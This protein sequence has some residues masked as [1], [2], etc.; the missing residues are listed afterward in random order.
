MSCTMTGASPSEGSSSNNSL[1]RDIK[2]RP[3]ASICCSPPLM[4]LAIWSLRSR[5]RGNR[6]KIDS[7][8]FSISALSLRTKAPRRRFSVTV[9]SLKTRLPSGTWAMPSFRILSA[10]I[11]SMFL[12]SN[13]ISPRDGWS[14]P[15]I[16]RRVVLLPAPFEPIKVTK[17]ESPT[18]SEMPFS[19]AT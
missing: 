16:A 18:S 12:P 4:V 11:F 13:R 3:I 9:K 1:G 19:A 8:S 14:S 5:N 17:S 15:E 10:D 6:S 7:R 2:A